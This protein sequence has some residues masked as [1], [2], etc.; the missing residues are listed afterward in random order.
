MPRIIRELFGRIDR[1]IPYNMREVENIVKYIVQYEKKYIYLSSAIVYCV[2]DNIIPKNGILYTCYNNS[3]DSLAVEKEF[4]LYVRYL[5]PIIHDKCDEFIVNYPF[6][7]R[8]L[9][10]MIKLLS[11]EKCN[12]HAI[13]SLLATF[14]MY[15]ITNQYTTYIMYLRYKL[16]IRLRNYMSLEYFKKLLFVHYIIMEFSSVRGNKMVQEVKNTYTFICQKIYSDFNESGDSKEHKNLL[17]YRNSSE[18]DD[19]KKSNNISELD[20]VSESGSASESGSVSEL[21][22]TD[23][24]N[25]FSR[26]NELIRRKKKRYCGKLFGT[27]ADA[28]CQCITPFDLSIIYTNKS[29]AI[30]LKHIYNYIIKSEYYQSQLISNYYRSKNSGRNI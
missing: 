27:R 22:G 17:E 5:L 4:N 1:C 8:L 14:E 10:M 30:N 11:D 3:I 25:D 6:R 20:S 18:F 28:L 24:S 19:S 16:L 15:E 21:S 26:S 7:D 29:T 12:V 9:D 2:S 13:T 23:E